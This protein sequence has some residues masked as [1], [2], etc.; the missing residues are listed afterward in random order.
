MQNRLNTASSMEIE[1]KPLSK[2]DA[3]VQAPSSKSYTNRALIIAS[4]AD[5]ISY[6]EE[7]LFSDDTKLM[8]EALQ[9]V[10]IAIP[11]EDQNITV[12]GRAGRI[13]LTGNRIF[14]GN[15]GTTLRFLACFLSLGHGRY[16]L[17]GNERM[18]QRPIQD[19]LDGLKQLGVKAYG[20]PKEGYPPV[21][22]EADGIAGGKV[23][24]SGENSSQYLSGILM[25][26]PYAQKAIEIE[27][28][29]SLVSR[30]Y[31]D[32]TLSIMKSFGVDVIQDQYKFFKVDAPQKYKPSYYKI[33]GDASNASYYF[34]AAAITGG[35]V[36]VTNLSHESKQG[37]IHFVDLLAQMGCNVQKGPDWIEVSGQFLKGIE[38]DLRDMPDI[39]QTLAIVA[40]FAKGKTVIKNI[41]HLKIKETD[42]IRDLAAEL[43]KIGA[44]VEAGEDY[45]IVSGGNLRP[46]RIETYKDH[47]MAMSFA[48]AGLKIPGILVQD[49][50]CV[51]KSFPDFWTR[52]EALYPQ[53]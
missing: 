24:M 52:L 35:K 43:Q 48:V 40:L 18:R 45:L 14:A 16:V 12:M 37:D 51:E 50:S 32:M 41:E 33:E 9:Q 23:V 7:C 42:R 39:V 21:V 11:I 47:R 49:P 25:A 15:A 44:N 46:A 28:K 2:I 27:I 6:L 8:I 13:G 17:D 30:P 29:G 5:G 38:A 34:A 19:L 36:R 20:E 10:G 3:V 22:I 1:I 31:V 53:T 4:L 26:A